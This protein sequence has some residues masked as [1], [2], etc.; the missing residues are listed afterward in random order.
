MLGDAGNWSGT[1]SALTGEGYRVIVPLLP[2]YELP[3]RQSN[4][5]ALVDHVAQF[6]AELGLDRAVVAGN[7]LGGHIALML[8]ISHGERVAALVLSGASGIYEV[9]MGSSTLRRKDK[10][11]IRDVA[12]TTFFDPRHATPELVDDVYEIVNDRLRALRLI[13]MARSVQAENVREDL[14]KLA[15]PTLLIWGREDGITP[16]DVAN[17]FHEEIRNSELYWVEE[18]GHAPMMEHPEIFNRIFLDF[19]GRVAVPTSVAE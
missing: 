17:I 12:A 16:P 8:A 4:V 9:D 10:I 6:M 18:C 1:V 7:S 13:R 2:V 5:P 15:M 14:E 11:Y 3:M 19:L